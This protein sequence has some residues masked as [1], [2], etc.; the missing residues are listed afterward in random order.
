MKRRAFKWDPA[1]DEDNQA[2][3]IKAPGSWK[4]MVVFREDETYKKEG[5]TH[6]A[7]SHAI[8]HLWEFD[9]PASDA[10]LKQALAAVKGMSEGVFV[11]DTKKKQ[12]I[13][14]REL[15]DKVKPAGM[16]NT[17][18][19]I[20][21]KIKNGT[22]L[23]PGEKKLVPLLRRMLQAYND[24]ISSVLSGAQDVEGMSEG[25]ILDAIR[26]RATLKAEGSFIG[27]DVT[28]YI[29]FGTSG[30]LAYVNGKVSTFFRLDKKGANPG[31]IAKYFLGSRAGVNSEALQKALADAAGE[32]AME[33]RAAAYL[34]A[35]IRRLYL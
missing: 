16:A 28:Y 4:Y 18:D 32:S 11:M 20:N 30:I 21:D 8:K 34:D 5:K 31:K 19:L 6:E 25:E 9:R 13:G 17:F 24:E 22:P 2:R 14:G 27:H 23:E 10:I 3:F 12:V 7:L 26:S 1:P 29:D 35:D 15:L 33:K